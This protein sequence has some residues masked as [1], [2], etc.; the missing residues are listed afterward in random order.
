MDIFKLKKSLPVDELWMSL[1]YQL[2]IGKDKFVWTTCL[3]QKL[4]QLDNKLKR[5]QN[6]TYLFLYDDFII[7]DFKNKKSKLFKLV[8]R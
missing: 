2:K 3:T 1:T 8:C 7:F 4:T 6:E 5:A